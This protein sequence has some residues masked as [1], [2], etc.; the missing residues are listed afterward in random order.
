MLPG[1]SGKFQE[2]VQRTQLALLAKGYSVGTI[3]GEVDAKTVAALYR[4]Q[5]DQ[6]MVPSGKLTSDT[7]S[8]LG[9]VAQ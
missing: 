4:Y 5:T 9:I 8:S 1:N 6:G 3:D 2:L 7:L